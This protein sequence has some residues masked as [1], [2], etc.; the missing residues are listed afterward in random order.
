[1][2]NDAGQRRRSSV[3]SPEDDLHRSE[4]LADLLI[5]CVSIGSVKREL[6]VCDLSK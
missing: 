2:V 6:E 3:V 5:A 1:V 4:H